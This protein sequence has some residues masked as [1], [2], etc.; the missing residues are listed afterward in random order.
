M[1]PPV[2][3][4]EPLRGVAIGL[5]H[6]D[7]TVPGDPDAKFRGGT[8]IADKFDHALDRIDLDCADG[9]GGG[10][11]A[12]LIF[13][14]RTPIRVASVTRGTTFSD[15]PKLR[16]ET[17]AAIFPLKKLVLPMKSATKGVAGRS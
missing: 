3:T 13:S 17:L 14:G 5:L 11:V 1:S 6:Q 4:S 9:A 10:A 7:M 12:I 15:R 8:E 2:A 16:L